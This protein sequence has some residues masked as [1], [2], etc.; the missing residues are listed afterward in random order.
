MNIW[1]NVLNDLNPQSSFDKFYEEFDSAFNL[2]FPIREVRF[3]KNIHKIEGFM[4]GGL[5]IS[6][7]KKL[8][9]GSIF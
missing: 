8:E 7:L 9:L 1:E 6:R 2:Y 3:N 4:T 5:M